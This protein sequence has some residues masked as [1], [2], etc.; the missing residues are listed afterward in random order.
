RGADIRPGDST[1][2]PL[3][4]FVARLVED[5]EMPPPGKGTALTAEQIGLLRAWIDQG[6]SWPDT[7]VL[8]TDSNRRAPGPPGATARQ[9]RKSEIRVPKSEIIPNLEPENSSQ[10]A[11]DF[12]RGSTE[13]DSQRDK[14]N[15]NGRHWAYLP[16]TR[17]ALPEVEDNNWIRNPVDQFILT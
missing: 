15:E 16:L 7:M 8:A 4:H 14:P 13:R 2:S 17:P 10:T 5:R 6:V 1:N 3:I 9:S 11:N 12:D